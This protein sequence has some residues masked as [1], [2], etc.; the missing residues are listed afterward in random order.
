MPTVPK[1]FI[2]LQVLGK[3]LKQTKRPNTDTN[4][5]QVNQA[6]HLEGSSLSRT[7]FTIQKSL[8]FSDSAVRN[9]N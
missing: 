9:S 6:V 8:N 5:S 2:F 3:S 1:M 7:K 4:I